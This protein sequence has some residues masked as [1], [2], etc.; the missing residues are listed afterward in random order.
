MIA[1]AVADL[2]FGAAFM[3]GAL[4]IRHEL[5]LRRWVGIADQLRLT[6]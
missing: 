2:T 1:M 6:R 3:A 4:V 5:K